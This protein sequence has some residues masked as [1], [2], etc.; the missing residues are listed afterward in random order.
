MNAK[1]IALLL[2]VL[3]VFGLF[4]TACDSSP[5]PSANGPS[6]EA[7]PP[8]GGGN[9]LDWEEQV[10]P[11]KNISAPPAGAIDFSDGNF[12]FV[13]MNLA[14]GDADPA[15]LSVIN[16]EGRS[17]L[18]VEL[19]QENN[20]YLG[21]DVSSLYG[22]KV[23]DIR[24]IEV[25]LWLQHPDGKFGAASGLL[26]VYT[27]TSNTL[28]EF[29]WAIT[30]DKYNPAVISAELGGDVSFVPDARNIVVLRKGTD[31]DAAAKTGRPAAN[32]IIDYI[33]CY[34]ASGNIIPAD[35]SASFAAPRGFGSADMS[36]LFEVED[37]VK[38]TFLDD[39]ATGT[40]SGWDQAGKIDKENF[41][42][43]LLKPGAVITVGFGGGKAPELVFQSWSNG[44]VGWAKVDPFMVNS[45]INLAQYRYEDIVAAFETDDFE[46]YLDRINIGA[47]DSN[48]DV[49]SFSIGQR[50]NEIEY[51]PVLLGDDGFID[52]TPFNIH[53]GN[54][55]S[56]GN[57]SQL[58][59]M[60]TDLSTE[61]PP[62]FKPE[63]LVEGSYI[64]A[65]YESEK[66]TQF[67]FQRFKDFGGEIW[68]GITGASQP[69]G[70]VTPEV[71]VDDVRVPRVGVDQISY[72]GILAM[73]ED[74]GGNPATFLD[75]LCA[76]WLQDD[77]TEYN[78]YK[79][80]L[81]TPPES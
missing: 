11:P 27:G 44:P 28:N 80:I 22:D 48:L 42:L 56:Q 32:F 47:R 79:V 78:L 68:G 33:A 14:P 49:K 34:D 75:E 3:F 73:W 7:P 31:S 29:V 76:F 5:S 55:Y 39:G 51:R 35:S 72:E 25:R 45:S 52:L 30:M 12:D 26:D 36:F 74:R 10:D 62:D 67:I 21:I 6:D 53:S 77:G 57:W 15:E 9:G 19:T 1:R 16:H 54:G 13:A 23:S 60:D 37:E 50:V 24:K 70:Y 18:K 58:F 17:A 69:G 2:S 41:D 61:N 40:A 66:V 63:W 8:S 64:T 43:D 38:Y 20:P 46:E 65:Y 71:T 59:R 4:L 81:Y